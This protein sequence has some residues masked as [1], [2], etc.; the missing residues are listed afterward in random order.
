M[1]NRH[2]KVDTEEASPRFILKLHKWFFSFIFIS[3]YTPNFL[4]PSLVKISV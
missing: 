4:E 1:L 3:K 2:R